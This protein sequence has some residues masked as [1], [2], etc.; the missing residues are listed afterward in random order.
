[1]DVVPLEVGA[2]VE[3]LLRGDYDAAYFRLLTTDTD[4]ALNLDFWLSS[5]SAHVWNPDQRA[6]ATPW[7]AEIDALMDRVTTSLDAEARHTAFAGVQRIV[8]REMP[9]MCF[10][11]PRVAVATSARVANAKPAAFRPPLLWD[12]GEIAVRSDAPR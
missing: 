6:P 11:F 2:L 3:R 12:A 7:E 1:V 10:A 8:A 4:P 9:V 5:G